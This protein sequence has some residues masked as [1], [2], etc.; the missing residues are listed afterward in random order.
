ML[1]RVVLLACV[2]A[3]ALSAQVTLQ[4]EQLR[5]ILKSSADQGLQDRE[6]AKYLEKQ[7][8]AFSMD[9]RLLEEV[10]G[11]G[12]GPKTLEALR[13]LQ[14]R[15]V[16]MPAPSLQPAKLQE[17]QQPPPP[18]QEEQDRI[19]AEARSAAL[20]YTDRL[21]DFICLQLTR[22]YVDP[23]GLDMDWVK[24]D[25]IKTRVSYFENHENYDVLSVNNKATSQSL[26]DL[27]GASSTGEFGSMLAELF[28]PMTGAEF[29]WA[30][31]SLLRGHGVYV[32]HYR[33]RRSRSRWRISFEK[34][35]EIIT[36]YTGLVYIDKDTERVLRITMDAEG[37]PST[38]PIREANSR[39]DYDYQEI[40]SG[41]YLLPL[42]AR[43]GMRQSKVRTRNEV[44]FRMYRKFSTE[45]VI[46]FDGIDDLEPLP[47]DTPLEEQRSPPQQ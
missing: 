24:Y 27:G 1:A 2:L 46:S 32:F 25:E 29:R 33:V 5:D 9:D 42:K 47:D 4:F 34:T 7:N 12:V 21:P 26:D 31:H 16:G 22:R 28:S 40:S 37:I 8:L 6:I 14:A 10:Q 13:K 38:F 41:K 43:I 39:L 45:A 20:E 23:S 15:A 11:W 19:I 17:P 44:E 30:R 18:S 3:L 35:D 36:G